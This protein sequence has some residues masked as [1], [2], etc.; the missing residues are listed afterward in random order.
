MKIRYLTAYCI[1]LHVMT[2]K[3]ERTT[4]YANTIVDVDECYLGTHSCDVNA[5]CTNTA[6]NYTCECNEGYEGNGLNCIGK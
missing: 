4:Q 5:V 6:G 1:N 3:K 2:K